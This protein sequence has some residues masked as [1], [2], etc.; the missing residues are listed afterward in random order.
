VI[1]SISKYAGKIMTEYDEGL[2]RHVAKAIQ[3]S[4]VI[5]ARKRIEEGK[6]AT[7]KIERTF[8]IAQA[9]A[10]RSSSILLFA[11]AED[12]MLDCLKV[13]LNP[14]A[15][16][17]WDSITGGNG[18][19]ATASDRISL[20][21]LLYWIQP[22]TGADLRLM[23]SIRNRFAHHAEV[24]SF[25]DNK[26]SGWVSSIHHHEKAAL[27]PIEYYRTKRPTIRNAYLMRAAGTLFHLV[28]DLAVGPIAMQERLDP[29][30]LFN[31]D[32]DRLPLNLQDAARAQA[33]LMLQVALDQVE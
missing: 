32:F 4:V 18:L 5:R 27:N 30:L 29:S 23:K 15:H 21:E 16:G 33:R 22:S 1:L 6:I 2:V 10:D 28:S 26:I 12:L 8:V 14:Q 24:H 19:L 17:G 25:S 13:H 9:E 31:R 20:L 7:E 11:L 3:E